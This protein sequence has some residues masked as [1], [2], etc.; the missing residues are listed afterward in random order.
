MELAFAALHQ[1]CAPMLDRLERLPDPQRDALGTAFGLTAG[2]SPDRFLIGLAVL[3]V[4]GRSGTS[5]ACT[6]PHTNFAASPDSARALLESEPAVI[7][8][9]LPMTEAI[10]RGRQAFGGLLEHDAQEVGLA[11]PH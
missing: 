5:H 7:G 10:V 2:P 4:Q 11:G 3:V 1:L 9:I 8:D 6:C